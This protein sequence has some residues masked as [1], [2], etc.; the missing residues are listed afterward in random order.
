MTE[1]KLEEITGHA[2][3]DRKVHILSRG[4]VQLTLDVEF[5]I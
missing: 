1:Q 3:E 4:R 5:D 2:R